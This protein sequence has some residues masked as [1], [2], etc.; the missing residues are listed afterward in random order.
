[1][2]E[3][4]MAQYTEIAYKNYAFPSGYY[5]SDK[6]DQGAYLYTFAMNKVGSSGK[7]LI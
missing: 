2:T 6:T 3:G 5:L 1:M 4:L 7:T